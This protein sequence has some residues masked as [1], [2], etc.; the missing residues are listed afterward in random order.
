MNSFM[1]VE[2][3]WNYLDLRDTI[4]SIS[5]IIRPIRKYIL[6]FSILVKSSV[7]KIQE[8]IHELLLHLQHSAHPAPTPHSLTQ[9]LFAEDTCFKCTNRK[10]LCCLFII[11]CC[12]WLAE[13]WRCPRTEATSVWQ[14]LLEGGGNPVYIYFPSIKTWH[15]SIRKN[16]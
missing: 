8:N 11:W 10:Y 7:G 3:S 15:C 9:R 14:H 12:I 1:L 5:I 2:S 4:I 13:M 6:G 16:K